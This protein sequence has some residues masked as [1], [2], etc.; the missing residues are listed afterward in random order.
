[1]VALLVPCQVPN[2]VVNYVQSDD[3]ISECCYHPLLVLGS[4]IKEICDI[5]Q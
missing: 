2:I 3:F 5:E 1:M 4:L